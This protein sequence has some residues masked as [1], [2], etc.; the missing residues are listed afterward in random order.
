[1]SL[2]RDSALA[3]LKAVGLTNAGIFAGKR[4]NNAVPIIEL[5]EWKDIRGLYHERLFLRS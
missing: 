1:M 2:D 5:I 4:D 3:L